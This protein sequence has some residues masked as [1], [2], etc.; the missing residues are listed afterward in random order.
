MDPS[1]YTGFYDERPDQIFDILYSIVFLCV[2]QSQFSMH[3]IIMIST[4]MAPYSLRSALLR[5]APYGTW[6][7]CAHYIENRVQ[8]GTQPHITPSDNI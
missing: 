1:N 3:D 7:K 2:S 8:F 5:P 4:Q 6:L